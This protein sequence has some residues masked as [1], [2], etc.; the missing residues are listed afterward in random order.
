MTESRGYRRSAFKPEDSFLWTETHHIDIS[1]GERGRGGGESE[2][3]L[4]LSIPNP[5]PYSALLVKSHYRFRPRASP[6]PAP[7]D[8]D[9]ALP[10]TP[11]PILRSKNVAVVG[12]PMMND[13]DTSVIRPADDST[14]FGHVFFRPCTYL[15]PIAALAAN[16]NPSDT[17]FLTPLLLP[18]LPATRS[19]S[20][21]RLPYEA[22]SSTTASPSNT[23]GESDTW[24]DRRLRPR[25]AAAAASASI[26]ALVPV[27]MVDECPSVRAVGRAE[28][29]EEEASTA[30]RRGS[31]RLRKGLRSICMIFFEVE[32]GSGL[33]WVEGS[34]SE[35]VEG[36]AT[37][38][39]G[40]TSTPE[41][42]PSPWRWGAGGRGSLRGVHKGIEAAL[43]AT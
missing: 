41:S 34:L 33:S 26:S 42:E 6:F 28:E 37:E 4:R 35:I 7:A 19:A 12:E 20:S 2:A 23:H 38:P 32:I 11:L 25:A 5:V 15:G 36:A 24:N 9:F 30:R 17:L 31:C 3:A 27:G 1:G 40:V 10:N 13:E 29:E 21:L 43:T 8:H 16:P 18:T 39:G 14:I 22:P